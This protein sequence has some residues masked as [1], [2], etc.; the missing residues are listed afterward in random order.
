MNYAT[1]AIISMTPI[2][3]NANPY[4]LVPVTAHGANGSIAF[5]RFISEP[6]QLYLI[7][8]QK[9]GVKKDSIY[10]EY[11]ILKYLKSKVSDN[12]IACIMS[13]EHGFQSIQNMTTPP[14]IIYHPDNYTFTNNLREN[15][16]LSKAMSCSTSLATLL[17]NGI[18]DEHVHKLDIFFRRLLHIRD[19][20]LSPGFCHNDF[21]TRNILYHSTGFFFLVDFGRAFA[22]KF[23]NAADQD[24]I[25]N[26]YPLNI[27]G[28]IDQLTFECDSFSY[29]SSPFNTNNL[30]CDFAGLIGICENTNRI[31]SECIY[32]TNIIHFNFIKKSWNWYNKYIKLN[33]NTVGG[34]GGQFYARDYNSFMSFE[35]QKIDMSHATEEIDRNIWPPASL[36]FPG[37]G[38]RRTLNLKRKMNG[39]REQDIHAY[40]PENVPE[41]K[42]KTKIVLEIEPPPIPNITKTDIN[43]TMETWKTWAETKDELSSE[44]PKSMSSL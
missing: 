38:C 41:P 11:I 35:A 7:K 33:G 23:A 21:H 1:Q 43:T 40:V 4:Y 13:I 10:H 9:N 14:E 30:W 27:P 25:R 26:T 16:F 39:G 42:S 29:K 12:F 8:M 3:S 34:M 37:G 19:T 24:D 31:F 32:G 17:K 22:D 20:F 15:C 5:L 6:K 18:T 2:L 36:N 44:K 28:E